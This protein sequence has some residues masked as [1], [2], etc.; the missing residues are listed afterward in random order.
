MLPAWHTCICLVLVILFLGLLAL[1]S[2]SQNTHTICPVYLMT[3][4]RGHL[5]R[6]LRGTNCPRCSCVVKN[7]AKGRCKSHK[8]AQLKGGSQRFLIKERATH[9]SAYYTPR[10]PTAV[11]H[12]GGRKGE[13][14][15]H[16]LRKKTEVS[17]YP[18]LEDDLESIEKKSLLSKCSAPPRGRQRQCWLGYDTPRSR[19][20]CCL[21]CS[22]KS[23]L[24]SQREALIW[25]NQAL[26]INPNSLQTSLL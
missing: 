22:T 13:T 25:K 20:G 11:K 23:H 9:K 3:N 10:V 26:K 7:I 1:M 19:A 4:T 5:W 18:E 8:N 15:R 2:Q 14:E 21:A 17:S 12:E 6:L 24:S 16:T